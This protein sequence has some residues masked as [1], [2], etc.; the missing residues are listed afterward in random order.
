MEK[1]KIGLLGAL[2]M[3]IGCIVGSGIFGT[4][5]TVANEYGA[6]VVWALI[7]A[8]FVVILRALALTYTAAA[9]PASGAQFLW[10]AKLIHPIAGAFISFGTLLMPT[11]VSLF[12]VLFAMYMEPLFP[13]LNINSTVAAVGLLVVFTVVAWFGNRTTVNLSNVMVVLLL[14]AIALYVFLGLPNIDADNVTFGEIVRPG[15]TF[16]SLAAAVGVLTSSLSGASSVAYVADDVKNPGRNVPLALILCPAIVAI[17]YV[18][19]A[20]VT[21]GVVPSAEV[22]SLSDVASHFMSP[23]LLTFFI[24]GG[25]ICGIIT[26]LVPVALAC[27]A[28]VESSA[29]NKVFP[30]ILAK[31]N[32]HGIAYWSLFLVMAIAIGIC[33]TGATFGV[34]MTIFSFCN[35]I[36]E[37]PN[38]VAPFFAHKKYPKSCDNSS[39]HM[40]EKVA[41]VLS[42]ATFVVCLYLSIQMAATLSKGAVLGILAVYVIGYVYFFIRVKYLK[43][44]GVDLIAYM[45]EPHEA[46]EEKEKSFQ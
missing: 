15:V 14:I 6:G 36:A 17:V 37:L 10:A 21:I 35:T 31:K 8:A 18:L 38:T 11:M 19:M 46:W 24:V 44:K 27:V 28:L 13:G 43:N 12:G 40:N 34:V 9:L 20:V 45:K 16:S 29:E 41:Y 26:S 23:A 2:L 33:A 3:G 39:L 22:T 32:K 4:L 1:K 30:E 7:G 25:P 5:P 42:I